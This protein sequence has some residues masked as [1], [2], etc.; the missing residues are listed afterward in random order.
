MMARA[1]RSSTADLKRKRSLDDDID[2]TETAPNKLARTDDGRDETECIIN[3]R[4]IL[5]VLETEDKQGLLDRVFPSTDSQKTVSLRAL[6][7]TP[8][9]LATIKAAINNLRP[10]SSLPRA[11]PSQTAAQQL[12]FC[13]LALS[14]LEQLS[15]ALVQHLPSG[16]LWTSLAS[17]SSP[18]NLQTANAELVAILPSPSSS[19]SDKP[20]PTLGSYSAKPL[21]QRKPPLAHRR[22][23]TG[24][25]LD[26]GVY[27]SFAPSFDQDGELV[28]RHQLGQVLMYREEKKHLRDAIRRERLEGVGS[29]VDATPENPEVSEQ[30]DPISVP[31]LELEALLPPEEVDSI[32]AA[33]GSL[34]LEKSVQRLLERNQRALERLEELQRHRLTNH[35]TSAAEEDS[36]EWETAHAILDSLTLL[37]SFRPRSSSEDGPALI[38]PPSVLHK[39]HLTLA[40]EPSPGWYGTLPPGRATALRDDSTVKVR[41]GVATPGPAVATPTTAVPT[42]ASA[43]NAFGTY[44]FAYGQ[45]PNYKPQQATAYMPYKPGQAPSYYQGYVQGGSQPTYYGQQSYGAASTNQQPYGTTV[46]QPYPAYS[47]WYGQQYA[48]QPIQTGTGGSGRGTPQ[49]I[50]A[51]PT[52]AGG[53]G[54]ASTGVRSPAVANTVVG[55]AVSG[56]GST[57]SPTVGAMPTLPAHLRT[58]Q[59]AVTT[60]G[61]PAPYQ[62]Q[63][64][65]YPYPIQQQ[66]QPA[67]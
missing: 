28:G 52:T 66:T 9:L 51:T 67:R 44:G 49:P 19:S 3:G 42:A 53:G 50:V 5:E 62:P 34:E 1:T 32:K 41:A 65:Y 11:R 27:S 40:T 18:T 37:A 47:S 15:Y 29:I 26:Y 59:T 35:P 10:I 2:N 20:V 60:N 23:T 57:Y 14:L 6:L 58:T 33:L 7:T 22:V 12:R 45:A 30:D 4:G 31:D 38:P 13:N 61:S 46:Q 36:E 21:S 17:L 56:S 54:G 55:N 39:L 63:Q 64:G 25:F 8:S 24:A 48:P 16:D 43:P